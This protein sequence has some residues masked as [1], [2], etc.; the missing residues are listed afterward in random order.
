[1]FAEIAQYFDNSPKSFRPGN[2]PYLS[3]RALQ[4][5][6]GLYG[7]N[8]EVVVDFY[9]YFRWFD[10]IADS[11]QMS[12]S[13]RLEFIE[14]QKNLIKYGTLEG[15]LLPI[16]KF[17]QRLPFDAIP[18][19]FHPQLKREFLNIAHSIGD[20]VRHFGL[21]PRT[22][23]QIHQN[24]IRTFLPYAETVSIALNRHSTRPTNHFIE[25]LDLWNY[26][27]ALLHLPKD[28]DEEK[29]IKIGFTKE[30]VAQITPLET[31]EA[32]R[33]KVLSIFNLGRY[34]REWEETLDRFRIVTTSFFELD[35]PF[36]Q[37]LISSMYLFLREPTRLPRLFRQ[38]EDRLYSC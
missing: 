7:R 19:E 4:A 16:E 32:R 35:M 12:H 8:G 22:R 20:D 5:C 6:H 21:F 28:L 24:N 23:R 29:I 1:M 34:R 17:Y 3:A 18:Q 25:L 14:R 13:Y 27:G 36:Y 38:V 10:N 15:T 30:E 2:E 33:E 11:P 26:L 37:M 9:T 31:V